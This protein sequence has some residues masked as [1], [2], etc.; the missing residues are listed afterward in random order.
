MSLPTLFL[1]DGSNQMYRAYHA[2][3]G[4]T[5]SDGKST[6][7]TYGFITMLRKLLADHQPQYIAASFD[8]RGTTFRSQ[9]AADYKA[10]RSPM[11]ATLPSRCPGCTKPAKPWASPIYTAEGYEA[12]DVIGTLAAKAGAH[13][14]QAAIVTGDKDFFQLVGD[15]IRVYNP[16]D[17]GTWYDAEG[18]KQKLGVAPSQVC[19]VLALMGDSIDNVKG[20]PG[21]GEKGARELIALMD[22][23]KRCCST[24]ARSSRRSIAK[25]CSAYADQARQSR[26]LV[27][28]DTIVDVPFEIERFKFRGADRERCYALFSKMEFRTLVPEFAPTASS[29]SKDYAVIE[30]DEAAGAPDGGTEGRRPL[31]PEG[32]HRRHRAGARHAGRHRGVDRRHRKARYIP[33]GHEGF[34]GGF[35]LA[36]ADA[37]ALLPPVLTD[38]SVQKIGHDLKADLI[39]LGR[40]GV[41]VQNPHG[42]DTM[43]GSYLVD[44]NRSSQ[45]LEPLALEQ[46]GYK[47]VTEDEVVGKGVKAV[48]FA[49]VPV[50]SVLVYAGERSRPRAAA[51]R[52]RGAG[53]RERRARSP[54]IAISSCRWCRSSRRSSAS[55]CAST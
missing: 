55:A 49:Q 38:P 12:D 40:H 39:V 11:P 5:R 31:Q 51:G 30:S 37:L 28:I 8:L 23:S 4:L 20:V 7:A 46:L 35:S 48:P 6:N 44:A 29:V 34:G 45:A 41:D 53:A 19:D 52:A 33:L 42:F 43:L 25:A 13:G 18:V 16:R 54:C 1:I 2:I 9:I 27:T 3:R 15:G 26:E 17:E 36:K 10:T 50:D 14:L 47:A 21:I 32:D 24:P 22:R